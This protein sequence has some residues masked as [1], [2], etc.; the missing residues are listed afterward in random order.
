MTG[1][2]SGIGR[3]VCATLVDWDGDVPSQYERFNVLGLDKAL[4]D[5][6]DLYEFQVCDVADPMQ[7]WKV[8]ERRDVD[9][10]INCAGVNNHMRRF[11]DM[12]VH[13]AKEVMDVNLWG[14]VRMTQASLRSLKERHGV[15]CNIIS[16][17]AHRPMRYSLAYN[18]SK[19]ALEMATKQLAREL[20]DHG[21]TVFGVSPNKV[22][23]TAMTRETDM[24]AGQLRGIRS[25]D[26]RAD[27]A[28]SQ[29]LAREEPTAAEVGAFIARLCVYNTWQ[30]AGC[31]Y[32]Y[33]GD[34]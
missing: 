30:M 18:A 17:A 32:Q 20:I 6:E 23:D 3:A 19:A 34:R 12:N 21:I 14:A 22:R 16:T 29:L 31:I 15:V 2:A 5:H 9:V 1:A 28:A 13:H 33:G 26:A 7:P 25:A 11:E 4:Q 27:Q 10:L 24:A 8:M